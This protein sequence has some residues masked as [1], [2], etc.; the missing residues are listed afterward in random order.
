MTTNTHTETAGSCLILAL[1]KINSGNRTAAKFYAIQAIGLA[2]DS[3]HPELNPL[4]ADECI[5]RATA[6]IWGR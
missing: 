6:L 2:T 1:E 5:A 4:N 3:A